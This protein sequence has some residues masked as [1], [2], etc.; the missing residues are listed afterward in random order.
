MIPGILQEMLKSW[1]SAHL[2]G[3]DASGE[4]EQLMLEEDGPVEVQESW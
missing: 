2:A 4:H 3:S 1:D